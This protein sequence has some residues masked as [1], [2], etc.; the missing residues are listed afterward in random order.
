MLFS[1]QVNGVLL[2]IVLVFMLVLVNNRRLMREHV[3]SKMQNILG[4]GTTI[5][6]IVLT[7]LLM[8]T[9]VFPNLI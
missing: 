5:A 2:P 1:Q 3:N 4:W 7:A 8:L 6:M 9:S